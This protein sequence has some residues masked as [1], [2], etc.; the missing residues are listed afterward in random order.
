MIPLVPDPRFQKIVLE[1]DPRTAQVR[2]S[3]VTDPDGSENAISFLDMKRNTKVSETFF[4][5]AP[6]PGTTI[7]DFT[8]PTP[9]K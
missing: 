3:T 4:R 9:K 5:L 1:V 6:P 8:T 7:Q 2:K